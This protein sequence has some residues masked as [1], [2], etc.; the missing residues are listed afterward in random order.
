MEIIKE[1]VFRKQLKKGLSGGYL[2]YGDEDY[3][4]GFALRSVKEELCSDPTYALFNHIELDA[5][6]YSP[7]ALLDAMMP[8]P[9][10]APASSCCP[11]PIRPPT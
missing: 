6:D 5:M 3:L 9:M 1:D 2:F 10:M 4:K 11:A 7:D 8:L